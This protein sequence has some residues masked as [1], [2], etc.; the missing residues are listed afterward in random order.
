VHDTNTLKPA[1]NQ[2]P[3]KEQREEDRKEKT[4]NQVVCESKTQISEE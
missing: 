4:Q 1:G 2:N 3:S